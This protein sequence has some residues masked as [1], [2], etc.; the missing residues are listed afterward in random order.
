MREKDIRSFAKRERGRKTA[1]H[2]QTT[3]MVAQ[4]TVRLHCGEG[5]KKSA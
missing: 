4:G 1:S 5:E 3:G 2:G